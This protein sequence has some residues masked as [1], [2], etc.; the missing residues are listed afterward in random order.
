[1]QR[2]F[3]LLSIL[4]LACLTIGAQTNESPD[5]PTIVETF[6]SI[7]DDH[8][9]HAKLNREGLT[10]SGLPMHT[11]VIGSNGLTA[12][13]ASKAGD[14][15]V[16][17]LN[18]IHPGESC[19]INASITFAEEKAA[20]PDDGITYVIIPVYNIGGCL[21]RRPN[22]RANQVGPELQG[23]RG[24][25]Q[26]LDLNRDFIKGDSKNTKSFAEI[27]HRWNP[28]ILIDTHTSN[29]AD[30]QPTMTL[31]TTFPEK[32][33]KMQAN[34]LSLEMEPAL[35]TGMEE[36]GNKMV[37]YV[38]TIK[39]TPDNG[40]KAFTDLP[41]YSIGY[42]ALFN[43][44]GFT[45]EA[46]M[47]KSFDD[48]V[49]A[50]LDIL[51]VI[52]EVAREKS[53]VL[54]TLKKLADDEDLNR[55][56]YSYGWKVSDQVDSLLFSGFEADSIPSEVTGELR[57]K[58]DRTKPYL[59]NIPY[60]KW[61]ESTE[62]FDIPEYYIIKQSAKK[63]IEMLDANQIEYRVLETDTLVNLTTQY[64]LSYETLDF[65]YEGHYL[66][67]KTAVR[68]GRS[69]IAVRAGDVLVKA[70]Q[71]GSKYLAH[72]LFPECADSFF[73]W[74]FFDSHLGQ[75]EYFSPYVFEDTAA[76]L[77]KKNKK[78]REEFESRK[79]SDADFAKDSYAQLK[80]IY[81]NSP[82]YEPSHKRMPVY[83][84]Y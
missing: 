44:I 83:L 52:S 16:L 22:T 32:L 60:Q 5:Y 50:T 25:Y 29:G 18:G 62:T 34:F 7:A 61:H 72:A 4:F 33:N 41:R 51:N 1:M 19:G 58:Y 3:S 36:K 35:Y 24:N 15:V 48:R 84:I 77:L 81:E 45:T 64:I 8:P 6:R 47:L 78:L 69:N 11:I 13:E 30:Y 17:I 80:F 12:E 2:R 27:F 70:R 66:H 76:E 21:D 65:P 55:T 39:G 28:H 53:D 37:P 74:N 26:N 71:K 9:E 38:N 79:A 63:A 10:D 68:P 14:L 56:T 59:K 75:K 57:L 73:N 40:I 20:N 31:L 42:A 46:H 54:K 23:F 82:Y 49:N 43:C 67:Y